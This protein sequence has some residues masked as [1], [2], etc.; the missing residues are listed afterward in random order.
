MV[1]LVSIGKSFIN[2][3]VWVFCLFD[4]VPF[5]RLIFLTEFVK[6]CSI[7]QVNFFITE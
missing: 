4:C 1:V 6:L 3:T 7:C 5:V 2:F